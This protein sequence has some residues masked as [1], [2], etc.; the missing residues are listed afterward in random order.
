MRHII[1]FGNPLH[2]DDGF[3]PAVYQQLLTMPLPSDVK[4]FDAGTTGLN[5]M[6]LFN[7][8]DEA[9]IVDALTPN[10]TPPCLLHLT[11]EQLTADMVVSGHAQGVVAVL[12][13]LSALNMLPERVEILAVRAQHVEPFSFTLSPAVANAVNECVKYLSHH[14]S[15]VSYA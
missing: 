3:G 8:C 5:A 14:F 11:P 10:G 12:H 4:V 6:T 1:C 15:S 2:G 9:I 7:D 13:S